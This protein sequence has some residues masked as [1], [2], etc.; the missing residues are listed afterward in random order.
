MKRKTLNDNTISIMLASLRPSFNKFNQNGI[1]LKCL[2]FSFVEKNRDS[3]M[4]NC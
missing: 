3:I 1:N 2:L 4:I